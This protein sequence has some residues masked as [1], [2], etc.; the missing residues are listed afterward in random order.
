MMSELDFSLTQTAGGGKT[1]TQGGKNVS[2][3]AGT[4]AKARVAQMGQA[5]VG[6]GVDDIKA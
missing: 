4:K 1:A 5:H 6:E 2:F 3:A